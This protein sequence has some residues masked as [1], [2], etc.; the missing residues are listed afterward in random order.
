MKFV[1]TR[2]VKSLNSGFR[3]I[4]PSKKEIDKFVVELEYLLD[5][6][7]EDEH[8]E[9]NKN[10]LA[11][12]LKSVSFHRQNFINTKYN[13]DLVIHEGKNSS[14][15]V[16]V[17][18]ETKSL[19]NR[20][21]MIDKTS[22]NKK[23]FHEIILYYL[24]E[25]LNEKNKS[26]KH[27]IV[28]D[29]INYYIF[30][31][32]DFEKCFIKSK[33]FIKL[34]Y[35]WSSGRLVD[36]TTSFFYNS[37]A[38]EFINTSDST[39]RFIHLNLKAISKKIKKNEY[40]PLLIRLFKVFSREHLLKLPFQND[41]NSLDKEF[42]NEL[43]YI[44][45]LEEQKIKGSNYIDRKK[46]PQ[47]GS[48]LELAI[49][50]LKSKSTTER[51]SIKET[52]IDY[53]SSRVKVA[54][55]LVVT[56]MNR[57]LFIKLLDSQLV[58]IHFGDL[59]YKILSLDNISSFDDLDEI[60]FQVLAEEKEKRSSE[61]K[62]YS[63][64]PY[65]NSSLFEPVN[66]E[67]SHIYMGNL[68]DGVEIE[69]YNKTV[70]KDLKGKRKTGV[71]SSI[72]YLLDFLNAFNFSA[73]DFETVS[74]SSNRLISASVL[75]LVFE[76]INGYKD[77]AFFTPGFITMHM[78][79]I[80][81]EKAVINKFSESY[82]KKLNSLDEIHNHIR[83]LKEA[84]DIIDSIRIC[85]PAVGSGHFLVSALNKIIEIKSY[86]N[87]LIDSDGKLLRDIDIEIVN[88]ELSI[89]DT[90]G[91][92]FKYNVNLKSSARIQSTLFKEKQKIIE[93]SLFGTDI[94]SNS[95]KICRLRLWIELLK[96]SYYE[97]GKL[98]TLPNIDI[99]IK[100]G[101]SLTYQF[102]LDDNIAS[103]ITIIKDKIAE[104]KSLVYEYKNESN[105]EIR[106]EISKSI[107]SL[108]SEFKS[109]IWS[110][111]KSR[112]DLLRLKNEYYNK[113]EAKR[114]FDTGNPNISTKNE[115]DLLNKIKKK[116]NELENIENNEI[117]NDAFEWRFEFP[118][119]LDEYGKF[120]GFDVIIGNPP[121]GFFNK[122]QN[123]KTALKIKKGLLPYIKNKFPNAVGGMI[124]AARF[125]VSLSLEILKD[126]GVSSM[127]IP[128]GFMTDK[129]TARFR[130]FIFDNKSI[131][132]IDA[133]PERDSKSKRVFED[134][135][136][137][138]C[139]LT[140]E[141]TTLEND[142]DKSFDM[143]VS[144]EKAVSEEINK[145]FYRDIKF[146]NPDLLKIPLSNEQELKILGKIY[147]LN[148]KTTFGDF[149]TCLTGEID[150]TNLSEVIVD[151]ETRFM[152]LKGAQIDKYLVKTFDKDI[153]QGSIQYVD[154]ST[155]GKIYKGLKLF[156]HEQKRIGLQGLTGINEIN[157]IKA[158]IVNKNFFLANSV[159]Y[160]LKPEKFSLESLIL[161]LNSKLMNWVYKQ[162]STSSNV[163][164]YEVDSLPLT[165][166]LLVLIE[167]IID[168]MNEPIVDNK[169]LEA[170]QN[171]ADQVIFSF[172]N[173]NPSE[174]EM[175]L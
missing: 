113:Y 45:G 52:N 51:Q 9:H 12:F 128:F 48:L 103:R 32:T 96:H 57:L 154:K 47:N 14:T 69:F 40:S 13:N 170:M 68:S 16:S 87:I 73:S 28:T 67:R 107:D 74:V 136:M 122:K 2:L 31:A 97:N 86:L 129:G 157:R 63:N 83:N 41:S 42:Y 149:S 150:I 4:P 61:L 35:D 85:D 158:T 90:D 137:S 100:V 10:L 17:I 19:I 95:V 147:Q 15:N 21:E 102:D 173:I 162:L 18:I 132:R 71:T 77:G 60:F 55:D 144:F 34:F 105:K 75:G 23:A 165:Y 168:S 116:E 53:R 146:L 50:Q 163:N 121:Y 126:G 1:E 66:V 119:A 26:I 161:I 175:M 29:T 58:N 125:F 27:L 109:N 38:H 142:D 155:L 148:G 143:S 82:G 110:S 93:N 72:E 20:N 92:F 111:K 159:N 135:K 145:F 5:N 151:E 59:S 169:M 3:K 30:D 78:C 171:D 104:Y 49:A 33:S 56:W 99:N 114:L 39:M 120:E 79:N 156:H 101:N 133:F 127:I 76:K 134:A 7:N 115:I 46:N 70:L 37:I 11:E 160:L 166:K 117:T 106:Y 174:I 167:E 98:V 25:R 130:R 91:N 65:L 36:S 118:E 54:I 108:K 141:N 80:S 94:N 138:T 124:N 22:F 89:T 81:I 153:S 24:R 139:I 152:L 43:L 44:L 84:N 62:K 164:G 8:E 112:R 88:D 123:Q 131:I 172:Y 140:I 64:I 6:V